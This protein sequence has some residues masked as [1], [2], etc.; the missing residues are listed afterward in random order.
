STRSHKRPPRWRL[1]ELRSSILLKLYRLICAAP[2]AFRIHHGRPV[3]VAIPGRR[4]FIRSM[5]SSSF[6]SSAPLAS[7][8]PGLELANAGANTEIAFD[9]GYSRE[10]SRDVVAG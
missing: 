2:A 9:F 5:I 4:D 1:E 6:E 7:G 10:H 3:G 8:E